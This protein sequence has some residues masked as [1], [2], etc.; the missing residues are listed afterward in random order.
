MDDITRPVGVVLVALAAFL[1]ACGGTATPAPTPSVQ[2]VPP[3]LGVAP[4]STL[5]PVPA[6]YQATYNTLQGQIA[7]FASSAPTTAP[8]STAVSS[9]LEPADGNAMKPGILQTNALSMS[10]TLIR[11]LHAL[12]ENSIAVQV[13]FPLLLSSWPDSSEYTSF[14]TQIAQAVHA[15]GMQLLVEEN[16][17]FP[18]ISS[19]ASSVTSFY[20]GLTLQSFSAAYQQQASTIITAMQPTYLSFLNEPD[21]YTG[22]LHNRALQLKD[23]TVGVK[24]VNAVLGGLNRNG[25]KMCA[26]TGTW[27]GAS[28][29][30]ALMSQTSIDCLDMHSYPIAPV[31]VTNMQSQV[32]AASA[33]HKPIVMSECWLYKSSTNGQPIENNSSGAI[34]EQ[35]TGTFSFWEPLDTAL[36][37]SMVNYARDQHFAVVSPFA[38]LNFFAYQDWTPALDSASETEVRSSFNRLASAA[39]HADQLSATGSAYSRV[40]EG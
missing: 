22:N 2:S 19:Q 15:E 33:A 3:T 5:A 25:T 24:F 38:T 1:A 11:E 23:A 28:Y 31:D 18:S 9:A 39:I 10:Q 21:T 32:T 17:L 26:G 16:P 8:N 34:N 30:Q 29:D 36:L 40:V 20:A 35:K 37:T 12:G 14:Y 7:S 6:Q 27:Q 4:S 13:S